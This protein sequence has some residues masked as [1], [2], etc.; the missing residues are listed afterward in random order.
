M[1][2]CYVNTIFA[3]ISE[4]QGFW[5]TRAAVAC[6]LRA[7][8]S[9]LQ[10]TLQGLRIRQIAEQLDFRSYFDSQLQRPKSVMR[11]NALT[12]CEPRARLRLMAD[13]FISP[14]HQTAVAF[15]DYWH[16]QHAQA[17]KVHDFERAERALRFALR[18]S[19]L[20]KIIEAA[21]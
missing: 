12:E 4:H 20:V 21:E 17:L 5:N 6:D 1:S 16:A 10:A 8:C 18:Y 3:L 2:D 19:K 7:N 11:A 13:E 14:E 15:R 9:A